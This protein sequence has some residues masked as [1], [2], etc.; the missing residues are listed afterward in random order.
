[1]SRHERRRGELGIRLF[2]RGEHRRASRQYGW[3]R[4]RSKPELGFRPLEAELRERE[5]ECIVGPPK[6]VACRGR[7]F[8]HRFAHPDRL[9]ALAWKKPNRLHRAAKY[10]RGR[11]PKKFPRRERT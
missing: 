5:A 4:I 3:V 7:A 8:V 6:N 1:M 2:E 11:S 9:R 10:Q